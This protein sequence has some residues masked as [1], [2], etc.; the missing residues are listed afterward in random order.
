MHVAEAGAGTNV[1]VMCSQ[2]YSTATAQKSHFGGWDRGVQVDRPTGSGRGE[3][4]VWARFQQ[5]WPPG[6]AGQSVN[7]ES[8]LSFGAARILFFRLTNGS[9]GGATKR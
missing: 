3:A 7:T 6:R 1:L 4:G 9:D 5:R 2:D 8:M